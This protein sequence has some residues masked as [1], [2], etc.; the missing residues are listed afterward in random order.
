MTTS[1]AEETTTSSAGDNRAC[2]DGRG[3]KD[4]C[5]SGK[6]IETGDRSSQKR[7]LCDGGGQK[8][9]LLHLQRI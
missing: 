5:S 2:F 9:E 6:G 7:P 3:G 8:E 1:V 4:K